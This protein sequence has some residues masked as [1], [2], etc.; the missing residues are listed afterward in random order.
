MPGGTTGDERN[1]KRESALTIMMKKKG[2]KGNPDPI[3]LGGEVGHEEEK[4]RARVKV[5]LR[6]VTR[7][8]LRVTFIVVADAQKEPIVSSSMTLPNKQNIK[9]RRV[10]IFNRAGPRTS[11]HR[12][13]SH[14]CGHCGTFPSS[15]YTTQ[16]E[17]TPKGAIWRHQFSFI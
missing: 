1:M 14:T 15:S 16:I 9:R 5:R 17:I 3:L 12:I 7:N 8:L 4:A 2:E 11:G 10:R 13:L 6:N